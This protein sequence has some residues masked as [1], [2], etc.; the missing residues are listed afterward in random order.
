[1][2]RLTFLQS[3]PRYSVEVALV[4]GGALV[5]LIQLSYTSMEAST[6]ILTLYLLGA[7]RILPAMVRLQ[8]GML[9]LRSSLTMSKPVFDLDR[10]LRL[11]LERRD[12]SLDP[13][14]LTHPGETGLVIDDLMFQ[15][16]GDGFAV[17]G[18]SVH[19]GRGQMLAL[20]GRSG[21]GKSTYANLILGLIPPSSGEVFFDGVPTRLLVGQGVA[22][23]WLRAAG[24]LHNRCL[25][26]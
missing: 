8:N 10:S 18:L 3:I 19:L 13:R 9:Q 1:M 23:V 26:A 14:R 24:V 21:S 7:S 6:G 12:P 15:Y 4:I 17:K 22:R 16:P 5:V 25:L 2:E 20:V 11:S